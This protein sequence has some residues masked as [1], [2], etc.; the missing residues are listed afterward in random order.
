MKTGIFKIAEQVD[1]YGFYGEILQQC[2]LN[3]NNLVQIEI[4]EHLSKWESGIALG[5]AYFVEIMRKRMGITV[6]IMEIRYNEI[7]TKHILISYIT[8]FALCDAFLLTPTNAPCFS[9]ETKSFNFPL[10]ASF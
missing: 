10:R 7:D 1:G 8:F 4:P 6:R 2:A 3:E 5:V 9:K